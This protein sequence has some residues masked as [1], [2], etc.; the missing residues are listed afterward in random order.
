MGKGLVTSRIRGVFRGGRRGG[1]GEGQLSR[2]KS[3]CCQVSEQDPNVSLH[4][5][6]NLLGLC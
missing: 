2:E 6:L 5:T 1:G 3:H 4:H